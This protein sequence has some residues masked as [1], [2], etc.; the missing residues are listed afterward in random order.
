MATCP[1]IEIAE[2]MKT[3][4]DAAVVA[5]T[6]SVPFD[7]RAGI[8]FEEKLPDLPGAG[9]RVL[10]PLVDI[11]IQPNPRIEVVGR[12]KFGHIVP[13]RIGLRQQLSSACYREDSTIDLDK[14]RPQLTLFYELMQFLMP[15]TTYPHGMVL[16]GSYAAFVPQINVMFAYH[17]ELL[18]TDKQYC[19]IFEVSYM[20]REAAP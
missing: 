4:F 5:G 17:P 14:I 19:G 8:V 18:Q 12:P 16:T 13:V 1:P 6:F 3:T 9:D 20:T 2:A 10:R 15:S 7:C 11:C